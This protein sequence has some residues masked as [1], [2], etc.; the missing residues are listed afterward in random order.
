MPRRT[1]TIAFFDD[2]KDIVEAY[3]RTFEYDGYAFLSADSP[4]TALELYESIKDTPPRFTVI[5]VIFKSFSSDKP[6]GFGLCRQLRTIDPEG[7]FI[8]L[9]GLD[10][11]LTRIRLIDSKADAILEKPKSDIEILAAVA[12]IER[13]RAEAKAKPQVLGAPRNHTLVVGF[14]VLF[15]A[16]VLGLSSI[17]AYDWHCQVVRDAK[18]DVANQ[19]ARDLV[20]SLFDQQQVNDKTRQDDKYAELDRRMHD[21]ESSSNGLWIDNRNIWGVLSS[22]G[23]SKSKGGK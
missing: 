4:K 14:A 17:G 9:T 1:N 2:D 6:N 5:D 12:K 20:K 15:G 23:M 10:D 22:H 18:Q 3:Q 7:I 13:E 16:L 21:V 11:S 8:I 19:A